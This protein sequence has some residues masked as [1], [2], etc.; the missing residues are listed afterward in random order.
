VHTA[1]ARQIVHHAL[2]QVILVAVMVMVLLS[3]SGWQVRTLRRY[4][5]LQ[6]EAARQERLAALGGMA[7]VLAHEIRNPLGAIKGLAQ[8]LGRN[9]PP[10]RPRW[11]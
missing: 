9:R 7:A 5:V 2:F 6:R 1:P 11:K 10:I 4:L 3:I 8:F